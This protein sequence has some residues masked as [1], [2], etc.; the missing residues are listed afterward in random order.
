MRPQ[1]LR[2]KVRAERTQCEGIAIA[3]R[4]V[5][6]RLARARASVD[7]DD[8]TQA[9]RTMIARRELPV[10]DSA[11]T[12]SSAYDN[13]GQLTSVTPP[14]S[15]AVTYHYDQNGTQ[16]DKGAGASFAWDAD[17]HLT[18]ATANGVTTTMAYN[19]D[20]VRQS[21]TSGGTTTT[22]TWDPQTSQILD[23]G[24]SQ[25]IYGAS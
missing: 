14:G 16:T 5:L 13:T 1:G 3:Q 18:S 21:R 4:A 23:D 24:A 8:R 17:N 12:T 20:G 25:T 22:Y 11:G 6:G 19:G 2:Q 9:V 10:L 15:G 7:H